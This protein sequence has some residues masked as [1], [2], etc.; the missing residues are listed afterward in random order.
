M[1]VHISFEQKELKYRWLLLIGFSLI[2]LAISWNADDAFHAYV[3]ARNLVEGNGFVYNVGYRVT[4][5]TCPLFTLIVA[6][7]YAIF[8]HMSFVGI[9]LGVLF[10]SLAAYMIIFRCCNIMKD[11]VLA[12]CIMLGSYC[13]MCYTTAGLENSLLFFLG[14]LFTDFYF[15]QDSFSGKGLF[16]LAL[17]LSLIAM[18]RMDAVLIFIPMICVGYIA[19]TREKWNVRILCGFTGLLPFI[20]WELFSIFYYGYPFPNT[21]YV[22]LNTGLAKMDYFA[23]GFDFIYQSGMMDI[24]LVLMPILLIAISFFR[25]IRDAMLLSIGIIIYNIYVI[26]IGGDFMLGRHLTVQFFLALYGLLL[27]KNQDDSLF[28]YKGNKVALTSFLMACCIIG[29]V[30]GTCVRM[31]AKDY[32]Y[33][34]TWDDTGTSVADEKSVYYPYTGLVP[35]TYNL[36]V[37]QKNMHVEMAKLEI[38]TIDSFR[39]KGDVGNYSWGVSGIAAFYEMDKGT[40]YLTDRY[41]LMDPLLSHLPAIKHEHWRVGHMVREEP[42]GY[43]ESIAAGKNLI[44]SEALHE[45][46]DK[47][48]MIITGDIWNKERLQTIWNMN[49]GK[50]DYLI[51]KYIGD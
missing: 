8:G 47:V 41:G 27:M 24:L 19:K 29:L 23:K 6:L 46:Y 15:K 34:S 11:A 44:R 22:K 5:T 35:Y 50:F 10:S 45:F 13:F 42:D 49:T 43:P 26:S 3:M 21:M 28:T 37:N 12:T 30:F 1:K 25:K 38:E 14:A 40:M 16:Y 31:I 2:V 48:L 7:G 36:V 39:T 20:L 9:A 51:Q 4:A 33:D 18:T 17:L 32:L